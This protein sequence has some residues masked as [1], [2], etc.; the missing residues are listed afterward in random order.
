MTETNLSDIAS[1]V[2]I[3]LSSTAKLV[4]RTRTPTKARDHCR[5]GLAG[6]PDDAV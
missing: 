6:S 5:D 4:K 2:A 3:E 1:A